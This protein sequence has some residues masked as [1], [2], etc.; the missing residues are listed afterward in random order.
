MLAL[1]LLAVAGLSV[2]CRS[3]AG[4]YFVAVGLAG[5]SFT[6]MYWAAVLAL[7]VLA[8]LGQS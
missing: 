8:S 6:Q 3:D 4:K 2:Y 5:F 1:L 7:Q